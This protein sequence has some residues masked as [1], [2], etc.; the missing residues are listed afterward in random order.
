M[1]TVSQ[2]PPLPSV[3]AETLSSDV[4][5]QNKNQTEIDVTHS[6]ITENS[7]TDANSAQASPTIT[8]KVVSPAKTF[9]PKKIKF[10]KCIIHIW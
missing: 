5:D 6:A 7:G 3:P 2:A 9:D 1:A 4:V 8:S 10:R